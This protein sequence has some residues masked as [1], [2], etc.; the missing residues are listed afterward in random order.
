MI[1]GVLA[2]L[3]SSLWFMSRVYQHG[4]LSVQ[5]HMHIGTRLVRSQGIL[6]AT[7][8]RF[9]A[10]VDTSSSFFYRLPILHGTIHEN[11]LSGS[12]W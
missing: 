3:L 10:A 4:V 7:V 1:A 5:V 6:V 12:R 11:F 9:V 8:I 2:L